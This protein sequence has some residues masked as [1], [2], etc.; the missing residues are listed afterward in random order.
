MINIIELNKVVCKEAIDKKTFVLVRNQST[1]FELYGKRITLSAPIGFEWDGATIPRVLWS[2]LGY[3]P[4]GIMLPPSLWHDYI[5]KHKGVVINMEDGDEVFISRKSCDLLFYYHC[6]HV[7][8]PERKAKRM[9]TG[10]RIG[11]VIYWR[12]LR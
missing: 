12:D 2:I 5:Y 11:G 10:V 7:G 1:T 4:A 9:Y 8:I 6:L 3:H